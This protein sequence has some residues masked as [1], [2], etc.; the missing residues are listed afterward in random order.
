MEYNDTISDEKIS[1]IKAKRG[2]ENIEELFKGIKN[3]DEEE[4]EEEEDKKEDKKK[5]E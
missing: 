3:D 1:A 5:E 2:I 4:Q